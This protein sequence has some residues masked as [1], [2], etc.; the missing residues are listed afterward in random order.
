MEKNKLAYLTRLRTLVSEMEADLGLS[1]LKE[2]EKKIYLAAADCA[3]NDK[4]VETRQLLDHAL[5]NDI[6][7]PTFYRALKNL[8]TEGRLVRVDAKRNVLFRLG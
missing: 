7:R 1:D 4:V 5:A 3:Q 2:S 8:E 6:A